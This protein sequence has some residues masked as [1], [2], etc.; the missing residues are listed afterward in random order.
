M[1]NAKDS[2]RINTASTNALKIQFKSLFLRVTTYITPSPSTET[3]LASMLATSG[4]L[5]YPFLKTEISNVYTAPQSVQE[6]DIRIATGEVLLH[7]LN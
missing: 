2:K 5:E 3:M 4:R 1:V 7:P 6:I